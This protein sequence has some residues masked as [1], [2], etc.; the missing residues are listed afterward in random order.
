MEKA[1]FEEKFLG[2][3][4]GCALGDAVGELAFRLLDKRPLLQSVSHSVMLTYTDDTA[5]TVAL[6]ESLLRKGRVHTEDL[7]ETFSRHFHRE[8][9]RGY[10]SGPPTVFAMVKSLRISYPQAAKE[11][12]GGAGSFGNGA[13]MRIAPLGLLLFHADPSRIYAEARASAEVTHAHPLGIDGAAIQAMAVA[14]AVNLDPKK[15][16]SPSSF[17][18]RLIF[19]ARTQEMRHKLRLVRRLLEERIPPLDAA[20]LLGQGVAVHLSLPFAIYAFL[21][22][23]ASF[24]DCIYCAVLNGGDR[25]TLGAM[26]GAL[27][28]AYLGVEAI[29]SGWLKKLENRPLLEKLARDLLKL[30][31]A[32]EEG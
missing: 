16:F 20:D 7:G 19:F 13:A 22:H 2:A 25:D 32:R 24:E 11:L 18:E 23:H 17:L 5:M 3:M 10:A 8:P 14:Q 12:Y 28:G 29:P 31:N 15:E 26:A 27:A 9:W 21:R 1:L 4:L 30:A 6:A